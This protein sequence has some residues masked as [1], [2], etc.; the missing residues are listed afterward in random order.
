M[1]VARGPLD[2]WR[3]RR[4]PSVLE[5]RGRPRT[6]PVC[7]CGIPGETRST[8]ERFRVV[9]TSGTWPTQG[10]FGHATLVIGVV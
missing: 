5:V 2:D 3:G 1:T 9:R 7:P 4:E 10:D 8:A 6:Q